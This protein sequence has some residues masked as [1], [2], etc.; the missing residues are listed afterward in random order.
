MKSNHTMKE[1]K[2]MQALLNSVRSIEKSPNLID[3]GKYVQEHPHLYPKC[4]QVTKLI[5]RDTSR[6]ILLCEFCG[7]FFVDILKHR[8]CSCDKFI[9]VRDH[10]WDKLIN[11]FD[12]ELSMAL[13][14]QDDDELLCALLGG[15]LGLILDDSVEDKFITLSLNFICNL[16]II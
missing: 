9:L 13:F 5:C 1:L 3:C 4:Y 6:D 8:V 7:K 2:M 12:V 10:F 14:N 15:D 16:D 11:N